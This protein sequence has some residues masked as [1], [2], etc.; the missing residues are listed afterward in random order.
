MLGDLRGLIFS[1]VYEETAV[2]WK[3]AMTNRRFALIGRKSCYD[4]CVIRMGGRNRP[5]KSTPTDSGAG[6]W[7]RF[8]DMCAS[9]HRELERDHGPAPAPAFR[10]D[11]LTVDKPSH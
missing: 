5:R 11:N 10:S 1:R 8:G 9:Q 3:Y 7:S 6:P 4:V 2:R